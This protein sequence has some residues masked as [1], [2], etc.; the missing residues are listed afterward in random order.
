MM[1]A[2]TISPPGIPSYP[3]ARKAVNSLSL[4]LWIRSIRRPQ[5]SQLCSRPAM[6]A[7]RR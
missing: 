6:L 3:R 7:R 2:Q 4:R 5:A 1:M